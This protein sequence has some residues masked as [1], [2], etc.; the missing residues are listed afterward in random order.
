MSLLEKFRV[1]DYLWPGLD[2]AAN[3]LGKSDQASTKPL[4]RDYF[5]ELR[6]AYGRETTALTFA[7]FGNEATFAQA[8]AVQRNL[9]ALREHA[10]STPNLVSFFAQALPFDRVS[11]DV[12]VFRTH[13]LSHGMTPGGWRWLA[14]QSRATVRKLV[15]GGLT[16]RSIAWINLL[17]K[18]NCELP[19]V[20]AQP[21]RPLGLAEIDDIAL[22]TLRYP[23]TYRD[24]ETSLVSLLRVA[25][26]AYPALRA[27]G[28][29]ETFTMD[30]ER[31]T[32]DQ[33]RR[34]RS[35][36]SFVVAGNTWRGVVRQVNEAFA[37][38]LRDAA[39]RRAAAEAEELKR[40]EKQVRLDSAMWT[41]L[42]PFSTIGG[43]DVVPLCTNAALVEEGK[44]LDHCVGDGDY[45]ELCWEGS[46]R[47]FSL[48]G[49]VSER[50][51]TLELVRL[52]D[53]WAVGQLKTFAN[54]PAPAMFSQVGRKVCQRY[55]AA[56]GLSRI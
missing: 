41:S 45:L 31:V 17:A 37:R 29:R 25:L 1:S 8:N 24:S 44:V 32:I 55:N 27:T 36:E 23:E 51:A 15:N 42:V 6:L 46:V 30:Y 7:I 14:R 10:A 39:E 2:G 22:G 48:R 4:V 43:I 19:A 34:I 12:G 28:E 13:A 38:R 53:R 5:S 26:S 56:A 49:K 52:R 35:R 11:S 18:T 33:V 50:R 16:P 40:A 21:G 3:L 9:G 54:I 20:L 47:L